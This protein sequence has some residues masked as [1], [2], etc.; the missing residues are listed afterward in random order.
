MSLRTSITGQVQNLETR[1][2]KYLNAALKQRQEIRNFWDVTYIQ[3]N[4]YPK[5]ATAAA[6]QINLLAKASYIKK[7]DVNTCMESSQSI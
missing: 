7:G 6:K 1:R 4:K 2:D 3:D 5:T